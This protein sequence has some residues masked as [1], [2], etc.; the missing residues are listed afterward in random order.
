MNKSLAIRLRKSIDENGP[1]YRHGLLSV[2]LS[3]RED[4]SAEPLETIEQDG[5]KT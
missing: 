1:A 4:G 3:S 5:V 2:T